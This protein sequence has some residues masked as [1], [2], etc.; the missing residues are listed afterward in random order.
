VRIAPGKV[1]KSIGFPDMLIADWSLADLD[2][3]SVYL[4]SVPAEQ[5][6]AAQTERG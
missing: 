1:G 2:P 6:A 3:D 5:P 4:E